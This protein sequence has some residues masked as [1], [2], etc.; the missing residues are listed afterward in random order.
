MKKNTITTEACKARIVDY[1]KNNPG[2]VRAQYVSLNGN[3]T[4][5]EN[6]EIPAHDIAAWKRIQKQKLPN[7]NT[8][9]LFECSR[10]TEALDFYEDTLRATVYDNGTEILTVVVAGE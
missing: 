9:R 2:C 1:I 7:G 5:P 10:T 3:T 6:F 8:E 4:L